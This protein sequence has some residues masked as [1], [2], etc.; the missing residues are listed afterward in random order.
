MPCN[1][2]YVYPD[3]IHCLQESASLTR[4][5]DLPVLEDCAGVTNTC[6]DIWNNNRCGNDVAYFQPVIDGDVI[7]ILTSFPLP[8]IPCGED[9][10]VTITLVDCCCPKEKTPCAGNNVYLRIR[11]DCVR[12]RIALNDFT[13]PH[14]AITLEPCPEAEPCGEDVLSPSE[15]ETW[16]DVWISYSADPTLGI[17][18]T[19]DGNILTATFDPQLFPIPDL[20]CFFVDNVNFCGFGVEGEIIE[21]V[22]EVCDLTPKACAPYAEYVMRIECLQSGAWFS[23]SP[24]PCSLSL[25]RPTNLGLQGAA[26]AAYLNLHLYDNIPPGVTG[27]VLFDGNFYYL[28]YI[29]DEAFLNTPAGAMFCNNFCAKGE[30]LPGAIGKPVIQ[31]FQLKMIHCC[32]G[33]PPPPTTTNETLTPLPDG[34]L[35]NW[36]IGVEQVT[37]SS[38]PEFKQVFAIDVS[39]IE[40]KC[41]GFKLVWNGYTYYSEC[42]KKVDCEKTV[43]LKGD[44][45]LYRDCCGNWYSPPKELCGTFFFENTYRIYGDLI[46]DGF[47]IDR[48]EDNTATDV[49]RKYK[50]RTRQLP[51]YV[52]QRLECIFAAPRIVYEGINLIFTGSVQQNVQGSR[53]FILNADFTSETDCHTQF[54]CTT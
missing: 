7:Y 24:E 26:L 45:Y 32:G 4:Y 17:S 18:I 49:T 10:P 1:Y 21:R 43:L 38:A 20:M 52:V 41:F 25:C 46:Y 48:D 51:P 35:L 15:L 44:G 42:Y 2:V 33:A 19:R 23:F 28:R 16:L 29:F 9:N 8:A 53:M 34:S 27:Q 54:A 5:D 37:E 6:A 30:E 39:T 36:W 31:Y 50:L 12:K 3:T 47:N 14:F 11:I 22:C 40:D 13:S